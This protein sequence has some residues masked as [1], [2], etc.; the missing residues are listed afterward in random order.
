MQW[1]RLFVQWHGLQRRETWGCR[2]SRFFKACWPQSNQQRVPSMIEQNQVMPLLLQACPSFEEDWLAHLAEYGDEP[3]LYVIA[4]DLARHLLMLHRAGR[5]QEL[6]PVV[7]AIEH[8]HVEGSI[9]VK[10][11][12]T[13]GILEGV[14]NVW[15]HD[16]ASLNE[17]EQMLGPESRRWWLGLNDF[18]DGKT[19]Q[20][21]PSA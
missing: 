13:I 8:M 3:L 16:R 5:D 9:W 17:F 4:G 6:I 18:W 11:F 20:V 15:A 12:A 19:A 2:K 21:L 1:V 7:G 14:Q 10:E